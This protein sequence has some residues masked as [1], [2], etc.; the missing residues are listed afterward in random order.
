[1]MDCW[2][3]SSFSVGFVVVFLFVCIC[4]VLFFEEWGVG[5]G[6]GGGLNCVRFKT[7]FCLESLF[8][9]R[10]CKPFVRQCFRDSMIFW[11]TFYGGVINDLSKILCSTKYA[12][13]SIDVHIDK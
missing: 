9:H 4:F 7:A 2:S 6:G 5:G 10:L 3:I 12:I 13:F 8:W 11:L 1:M